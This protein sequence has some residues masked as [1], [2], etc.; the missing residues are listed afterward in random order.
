MPADVTTVKITP[1]LVLR[2]DGHAP[3]TK[4]SASCDTEMTPD[5]SPLPGETLATAW[6]QRTS[7][8]AVKLTHLETGSGKLD[9]QVY[10]TTTREFQRTVVHLAPDIPPAMLLEWLQADYHEIVQA[11]QLGSNRTYLLTFQGQGVPRRIRA[12]HEIIQ[13]KLYRPST[14]VCNNC[15]GRGQ[16]SDI[17]T[18]EKHC[19]FCDGL[20]TEGH[21]CETVKCRNCDS[22]DDVAT[23]RDCPDR[24]KVDSR[25]QAR[26]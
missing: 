24:K 8:V 10:R 19:Q 20:L 3:S 15:H 14:V 22:Q 13:V 18:Q 6:K 16:K 7:A 9:V 12:W 1:Q 5:S 11:R 2:Y 4:L 25:I 26:F 17:C 21:H 23:S